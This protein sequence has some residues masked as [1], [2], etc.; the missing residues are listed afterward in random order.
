MKELKI[1]LFPLINKLE[2]A[3][4]RGF[5]MDLLA[6]NYQSVYKGKG[7]E[8]VG[9]REYNPDD[10]AMLIDWKASLRAHKSVVRLL[11]EERNITVF[12]LL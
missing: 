6:G 9:F 7:M 12:F 2:A 10:D 11:Q 3:L 4:K 1:D 5:T 8:F